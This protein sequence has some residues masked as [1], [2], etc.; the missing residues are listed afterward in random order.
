MSQ[1]A[2]AWPPIYTWE[3]PSKGTSEDSPSTT[4]SVTCIY[5]GHKE[6]SKKEFAQFGRGLK[7]TKYTTTLVAGCL[8]RIQT[9]FIE[10]K[11]E[12]S[13]KNNRVKYLLCTRLVAYSNPPLGG[14][15]NRKALCK[16]CLKI[17]TKLTKSLPWELVRAS[18]SNC[19]R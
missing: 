8:Y 4:E 15:T 13:K 3:D 11:K 9:L 5:K 17:W 14:E 2:G 16:R 12:N 19:I 1:N 18:P 6:Q 10:K 7:R